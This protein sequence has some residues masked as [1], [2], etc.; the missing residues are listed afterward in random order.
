MNILVRLDISKNIGTGHFRRMKNLSEYMKEDNFIF[1]IKTDDPHNTLFHN[2]KIIFLS[3]NEFEMMHKSIQEFAIDLI[4][5]DL[6]HYPEGYIQSIKSSTSK[7][8]VT[9]HEYEDYSSFSDLTINY[10]FFNNY[11][12][13]KKDNFLAG[14]EYIILNDNI[15]LIP[16]KITKQDYVFVS[17]GGSDP[18]H[19]LEKFLQNVAVKLKDIKFKVHIGNF[20]KNNFELFHQYPH[21]EFLQSPLNILEYMNSAKCAIT[22][23]GNIMYELMYFK[24]PMLVVAHNAHQDEFA[25]N[26]SSYSSVVYCGLMDSIDFSEIRHEIVALYDADEKACYSYPLIDGLGIQRIAQAIKRVA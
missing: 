21:I 13:M 5:L 16:Q 6:L 22:A 15:H 2:E 12:A 17:F 19:F 7:K 18:S 1:C 14:P 10:N 4:I 11:L 23:A 8:V 26:A 24:I 20:N 3:G 9:F 25:K